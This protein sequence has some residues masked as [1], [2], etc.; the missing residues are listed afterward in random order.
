MACAKIIRIRGKSCDLVMIFFEVVFDALIYLY[1]LYS[2]IWIWSFYLLEC[3][4]IRWNECE[5][6]QEHKLSTKNST[7]LA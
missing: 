7:Q 2:T 3:A 6:H 1:I 5:T 4:R